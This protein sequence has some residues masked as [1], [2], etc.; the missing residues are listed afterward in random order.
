MIPLNIPR[1]KPQSILTLSNFIGGLNNRNAATEIADNESPDLLNVEFSETGAVSKRN[2]TALVGN[3]KGNS[4][5]LGLYSWYYGNGSAQLLMASQ[6]LSTAG[7]AYRTT[8]NFT[9]ATLDAGGTKLANADASMESFWDGTRQCV[10]I[11]DGTTFQ[12]YYDNGGTFTVYAATASPAS[13]GNI[14]RVFRNRLYSVGSTSLPERVY[15][16]DLGDGDAWTAANL[17]DVPSETTNQKGTTGDP[18]TALA[19]FQDRLIIF[20]NRG[21][22]FWDTVSL[23]QITDQHG[24]VG[25]RAFAVHDNYLY[26]ADNDGVYRMS[27]NFIEKC[28]KKIQGTWDAIPAA[29]IPEIAMKSF[30]DRIFVATAAAGASTNN[31]VLVN[32]P[33]LPRDNE[34]QHPWTYWA[35]TS[36]D[37]MAISEL[38]VYEASTTTLPILVGGLANAESMTMQLD[39]G[40]GD[41]DQSAG[42]QVIAISSYYRTK[43]FSLPARFYKQFVTYKVQSAASLLQVLTSIDFETMTSVN[44]FQM[45]QAATSV[46]GTGVY[47][48]AIYGGQ[49]AL[50][51]RGNVSMNG[52]FAQFQFSNPNASEPFTVYRLQQIY[53]PLRLR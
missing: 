46:Y 44:N 28:S 8:G 38:A 39:T 25:K 37:P 27:G 31:I 19:V 22:W 42:T 35:S 12:K 36:G 3:D 2:G 34:G 53:K 32:Y 18:I 50:I 51:G 15:F 10:F 23:R 40:N 11:A 29:R 17:F 20:K 7:L 52:K 26:F 5:V 4:K 13:V 47:G 30:Q 21:I 6:G 33:N 24:C 45:Q 43:T 1:R 16:S 49:N 9:E 41:L 48:T 14:L